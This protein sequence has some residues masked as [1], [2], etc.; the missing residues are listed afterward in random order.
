M[1][2]I[3]EEAKKLGPEITG[4]RRHL[5]GIPELGL[6]TPKT[7][8]YIVEELKKMGVKE[9]REKVGGWGVTALV[10]GDLPGKVLAV[11]A[12][13]DALPI[14]EET[15]LPFAAT[16]G[17]MHACGHDGHVAMALGAAKLLLAHKKELAGTVKFIFQ[18]AEENVQGAKAMLDDGALKNP[19]VDALIGLHTGCL[20]KE[21]GPGEIGVRYGSL[22]AAVDRFQITFRGKGGHGATPHLAVDPVTM[23]STAVLELQTILSREL[24]PLDPAVLTIGRIAGGR[25]FNIIADEC[26]LEGTVRTLKPETRAFVEERIRAISER[27]AEGMRGKATVEYDA[28]PPAL[29]N[30]VDFTRAFQTFA[31]TVAGADN[32][33]EISE[34]TMGGE[35]VAYFLEK[36]P[37]TFFVH[38]G[39]NPEKGQTW[40]HHNSKFD[41]DEET[42]PLGSALF[43][44]FALTWQK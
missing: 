43:A 18:P 2:S 29:I 38:G 13:C 6:E 33:K 24:S 39:C 28:G 31:A 35:D 22:M 5:H 20:W 16:N 32:V 21:I 10:K 34:P 42:F 23:A 14:Q 12:D 1:N 25:A 40:P 17:L 19:Q 30:D 9:I 8:A 3:L 27:V 15:G 26:V 41:L 11:R 36:V 37:G 7:S 44:G 4:W